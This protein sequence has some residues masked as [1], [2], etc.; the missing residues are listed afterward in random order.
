MDLVSLNHKTTSRAEH[1]STGSVSQFEAATPSAQAC[2]ALVRVLARQAARVWLRQQDCPSGKP[3][4]LT[5]DGA[6]DVDVV[7]DPRPHI[8]D[9]RHGE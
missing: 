3:K 1:C 9:N 2:L 6:S 8:G 7:T 5:D 4:S